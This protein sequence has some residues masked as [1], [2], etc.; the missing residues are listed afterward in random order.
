MTTPST[1]AST[2]I[3]RLAI[4]VGTG[5]ALACAIASHGPSIAP[6][7]VVRLDP[8]VVTISKVRFDAIRAEA[9]GTTMIGAAAKKARQ[10]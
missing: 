1:N 10:G 4:A 7:D 6:Q 3:G 9:Q 5:F 2:M 8:V